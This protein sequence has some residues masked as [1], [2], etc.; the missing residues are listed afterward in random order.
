MPSMLKNIS[1]DTI[2]HEHLEYYSLKS[3][4]YILK[5]AKLKIID[6]SLN[7]VN[8]GSFAITVCKKNS[9]IKA[10]ESVLTWMKNEEN[11]LRL[12]NI[13][14]YLNF[15]NNVKKQSKTLKNLLISL[16]KNKKKVIGYGASTKGNVIL[17]YTKINQNLLPFIVDVNKFKYNRFTPGTNIKIVNEKK[18]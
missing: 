2:C 14:T 8:G 13:K 10:N 11:K 16:K 18:N 3:I 5:Q 15:Y 4:N 1:Y 17:Q 7:S 6:A 9:K 12:N